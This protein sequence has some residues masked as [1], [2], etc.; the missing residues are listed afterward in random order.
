M[1][2][3]ELVSVKERFEADL[4]AVK[5]A[6]K[7]LK[8][9]CSLNL[10]PVWWQVKGKIQK[11]QCIWGFICRGKGEGAGGFQGEFMG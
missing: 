10:S 5:M 9:L 4:K 3:V 2:K 7:A 11:S 8:S 1:I 6:I